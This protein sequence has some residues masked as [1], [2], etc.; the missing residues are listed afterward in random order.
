MSCAGPRAG[1]DDPFGS[2]SNSCYS[3]VLSFPPLC[4]LPSPF[5]PILYL[6]PA[7]SLWD[8][9]RADMLPVVHGDGSCHTSAVCELSGSLCSSWHESLHVSSM[10]CGHA[11][12]C[13]A[14]SWLQYSMHFPLIAAPMQ[15]WMAAGSNVPSSNNT[16]ACQHCPVVVV[17]GHFRVAW[18]WS[19]V[20]SM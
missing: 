9:M 12:V 16:S 17:P 10:H 3:M 20:F 14:N 11:A 13:E 18:P 6:S 19:H 4:N 1:L 5:C 7:A 8:A 2:L 15:S